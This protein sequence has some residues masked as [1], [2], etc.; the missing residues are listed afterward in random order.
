M[1]HNIPVTSVKLNLCL[2]TQ[3][4]RHGDISGSGDIAPRVFNSEQDGGE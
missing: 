2:I 4:P 3:A 1:A